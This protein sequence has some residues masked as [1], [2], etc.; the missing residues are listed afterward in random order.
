VFHQL[1]VELKLPARDGVRPPTL[2]SLRHSFAVGCL[3][4]WYREGLD[5]AAR[6]HRLSTFMG[7]VDPSSTQVYLTI[8]P[9]LLEEANR[10]FEA[11]AKPAWAALET[12]R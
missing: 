7:H 2:T 10:R 3:L 12:E 4:R 6:L 8:T 1:V 9:A 11:F 5:P